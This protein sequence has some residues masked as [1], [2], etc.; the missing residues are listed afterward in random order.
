MKQQAQKEK[1]EAEKKL[2]KER[3]ERH[4]QM[5]Q[6]KKRKKSPSWL[7]NLDEEQR[8]MYQGL[9]FA[10]LPLVTNLPTEVSNT[11][12]RFSPQAKLNS[13][14]QGESSLGGGGGANN[15]KLMG[16]NMS[17]EDATDSKVFKIKTLNKLN[18]EET[19]HSPFATAGK[20]PTTTS[21]IGG[22]KQQKS[23]IALQ[24]GKE[25]LELP[26]LE[27]SVSIKAGIV[28]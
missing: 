5:N 13:P 17:R 22:V 19:K 2:R 12:S 21:S 27:A 1:E 8:R 10:S 4:I 25:P 6:R 9:K 16:R 28:S 24:E 23:R 26:K 20:Q 3:I 11:A 14:R 18:E 7:D 15:S